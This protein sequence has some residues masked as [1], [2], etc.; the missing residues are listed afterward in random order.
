VSRM[1]LDHGQKC[2]VLQ[3][4]ELRGNVRMQLE[5]NFP[6]PAGEGLP[7]AVIPSAAR[8]PVLAA[9]SA[10]SRPLPPLPAKEGRGEGR[11]RERRS[12]PS[13]FA[14][15]RVI[16]SGA[17]RPPEERPPVVGNASPMRGV[18]DPV[19]E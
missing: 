18:Y 5:G 19:L 11:P 7:K 6:S 13:F 8:D 16:L 4:H 14:A 3:V 12:T 17:S 9:P 10:S 15:L 1:R 2:R